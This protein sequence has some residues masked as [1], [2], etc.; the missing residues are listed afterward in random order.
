MAELLAFRCQAGAAFEFFERQGI[1]DVL[2][3]NDDVSDD[4]TGIARKAAAKAA[5]AA[6]AAGGASAAARAGA[7]RRGGMEK[8]RKDR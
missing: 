7:A 3:S 4:A 1:V 8:E 5:A 2:T 6:G